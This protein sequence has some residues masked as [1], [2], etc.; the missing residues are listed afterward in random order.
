[1]KELDGTSPPWHFRCGVVL[2]NDSVLVK[3]SETSC[4]SSGKLLSFETFCVKKN[5]RTTNFIK[6]DQ[7]TSFGVPKEYWR[8]SKYQLKEMA[9]G[10]AFRFHNIRA[11]D[12]GLERV[13]AYVGGHKLDNGQLLLA[14][15]NR[16]A[17]NNESGADDAAKELEILAMRPVNGASY[18]RIL[19]KEELQR[20][21]LGV[22]PSRKQLADL[23]N[24][25]SLPEELSQCPQLPEQL[26]SI[27]LQPTSSNQEHW[28]EWCKDKLAVFGGVF[29]LDGKSMPLTVFNKGVRFAVVGLDPTSRE[30]LCLSLNLEQGAELS[31][32]GYSQIENQLA[33]NNSNKAQKKSSCQT[34]LH[35]M[36]VC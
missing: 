33:D 2:D 20:L 1:M 7:F 16:F 18:S 25:L 5:L 10:L 6:A 36:P 24:R 19:S 28:P 4:V 8:A 29:E 3:I 15:A 12:A 27:P 21:G 17:N 23:F 11:V 14:A 32:A 34:A 31:R 9:V 30:P 13:T 26:G 22:C 35:R